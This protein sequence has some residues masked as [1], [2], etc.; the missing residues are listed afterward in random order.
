MVYKRDLLHALMVLG[1]FP[2][3]D[4]L[5]LLEAHLEELGATAGEIFSLVG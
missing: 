4:C 5:P 2:G 3:I 1:H